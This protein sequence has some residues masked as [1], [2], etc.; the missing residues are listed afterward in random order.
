MPRVD[1]T[2]ENKVAR[3][4]GTPEIVCGNNDY[5]LVFDFDDEWSMYEEMTARFAWCDLKTGKIKH[6]DVLFSGD[7]VLMPAL[8]DTAAVAVGVYAGN[9]HTTTPA[10]I[11]C[12]RCITDGEPL[13]EDPDPDV[14][15]QLLEYLESLGK[16]GGS[17]PQFVRRKIAAV[18]AGEQIVFP[19]TAAMRT[20]IIEEQEQLRKAAEIEESE[21]K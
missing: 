20:R 1:I 13:H 5:A 17:A 14:Y 10:R 15:E 2:V 12:A 6:T 18:S 9:I 21:V 16:G 7:T 3:T 8:Y 4:S 11:P 19:E